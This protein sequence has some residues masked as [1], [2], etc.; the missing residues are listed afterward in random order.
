[1][2]NVPLPCVA[3]R[4]DVEYPNIRANGTTTFIS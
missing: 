2:V 3:D 1:M 4:N